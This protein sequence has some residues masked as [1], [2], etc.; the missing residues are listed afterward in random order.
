MLR[1]KGLILSYPVV[2]A[3]K[4]SA[5]MG[6][7][8][9]LLGDKYR[10]V[11]ENLS[12]EKQVGQHTPPCFI[13][14]TFEDNTVPVENALLLAM[15]LR[16]SKVPTELHIFQKGIHGLGP[17]TKLVEKPDGSGVQ[18]ECQC[19]VDLADTW[20]NNLCNDIKENE[21]E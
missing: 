17:A 18:K 9:N 5:H 16:K 19:W 8:Q 7:F 13:W 3:D 14:H 12:L 11:K 2:T 1:P 4:E 10:K 6:S 15:A 20:L 21:D